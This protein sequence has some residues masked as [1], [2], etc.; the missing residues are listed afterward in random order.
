[1]NNLKKISILFL[2]FYFGILSPIRA[3][4]NAN[5]KSFYNGLHYLR[6]ALNFQ[7][8]KDFLPALHYFQLADSALSSQKSFA[9]LFLIHFYQAKIY[10]QIYRDSRQALYYFNEALNDYQK[11]HRP[12]KASFLPFVAY[13]HFTKGMILIETNHKQSI[14]SIQQAQKLYRKLNDAKN[15]KRCR[16]VLEKMQSS[17]KTKESL[18]TFQADF[19]INHLREKLKEAS[20]AE[21]SA[22][23]LHKIG[24]QLLLAEKY[25]EALDYLAQA[26]SLFKK[27]KQ[28]GSIIGEENTLGYLYFVVGDYSKSLQTYQMA[29]KQPDADHYPNLIWYSYYGLAKCEQLAEHDSLSYRYFKH[30]IQFIESYRATVFDYQSRIFYFEDKVTVYRDFVDFLIHLN[31]VDEAFAYVE[32]SQARAFLDILE[33][34]RLKSGQQKPLAI[35]QK[36]RAF[37]PVALQHIPR[38]L[39]SGQAFMSYFYSLDNLFIWVVTPKGYWFK[40]VPI[41]TTALITEVRLFRQS[42]EHLNDEYRHWAHNLYRVLI[43]PIQSRLGETDEMLISPS[44]AL[45]ELPFS[46]L[47]N[48]NGRYLI[49]SFRIHYLPGAS[50]LQQAKECGWGIRKVLAV[51]STAAPT[52]Q[53][54]LKYSVQEAEDIKKYFPQTTLLLGKNA[55]ENLVK[56]NLDADLLHFACHAFLNRD[57]PLKS[58]LLLEKSTVDDG[59]WTV[60]EIFQAHTNAHLVVLSACRSGLGKRYRGD[61]IVSLSR[62][63]MAAGS[64]EVIASL[65]EVNDASTH[66][67]MEDF[68]RYL[69]KGGDPAK[70][71]QEAQVDMIQG[72]LHVP[73]LRASHP[74]YWAPFL[75]FGD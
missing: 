3:Q 72:K 29:V 64:P 42:V 38:L 37:Y 10:Y 31:R 55:T 5:Q 67:L 44:G 56:Q 47:L 7:K 14:E 2:F 6:E 21:D 52:N 23:L 61:E 45:N 34:H 36:V 12:Q 63:F 49:E 13:V 58:Y 53:E 75:L 4:E 11:I 48:K 19:S 65:W 68:Y 26:L 20:S 51:G 66:L 60:A 16:R 22:K 18:F 39:N 24:R 35:E 70:A 15:A 30:S 73:G 62:A 71:L 74:F 33:A 40:K 1:M 28:T 27:A 50:L 32:R 57:H 69:K 9:N 54:R 43:E 41:S 17:I 46:V 59:R 8:E 25:P